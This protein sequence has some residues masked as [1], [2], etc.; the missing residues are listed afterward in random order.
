MAITSVK[1]FSALSRSSVEGGVAN[2]KRAGK[3][4]YFLLR[5]SQALLGGV[6]LQGQFNQP[7]DELG[8]RQTGIFPHLRVHAYGGESGDGIDLVNVELIGGSFEQKIH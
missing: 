2:K 8:H 6:P 3:S 1:R 4:I 7:V 5:I